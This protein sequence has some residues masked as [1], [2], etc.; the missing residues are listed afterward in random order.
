MGRVDEVALAVV[1]ANLEAI[2][3]LRAEV[4]P[5]WPEPEEA[6]LLAR[7]QFDAS[8]ILKSLGDGVP[9]GKRRLGLTPLDL[10]LPVFTYVFGEAQ[11]GGRAAVLSLYRLWGPGE[12][13]GSAPRSVFYTRLVKVALHE[14]AHV[15][16]V[17]HCR[18]LGCLMSF[19]RGLEQ[20]D[21][22][23]LGFC[24]DCQVSVMRGRRALTAE[25]ARRT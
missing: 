22:L 9:P 8:V 3:G 25:S 7:N 20:V 4:V 16:G 17:R 19:S 13:V 21:Q 6:L 10:C 5:A 18:R 14:T 2:M 23:E 1:A 11:M 12:P 24:P 15:L